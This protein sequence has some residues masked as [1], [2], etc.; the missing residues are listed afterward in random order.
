MIVSLNTAAAAADIES[1]YAAAAAAAAAKFSPADAT[2]ECVQCGAGWTAYW[3]RDQAGHYLCGTCIGLYRPKVDDIGR[4]L[5]ARQKPV[6]VTPG[7]Q[8]LNLPAV[9]SLPNVFIRLESRLNKSTIGLNITSLT[10]ILLYTTI[11]SVFV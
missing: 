5:H 11:L 2:A 4:I 8:L 1:R 7:K 6:T 10:K 3:R 9:S